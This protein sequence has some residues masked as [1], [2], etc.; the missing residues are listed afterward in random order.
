MPGVQ[1]PTKD[2]KFDIKGQ[3]DGRVALE[4]SK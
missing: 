3:P 1:G 4:G 2:Y